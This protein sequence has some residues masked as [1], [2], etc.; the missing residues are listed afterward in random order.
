MP[1]PVTGTSDLERAV[2]AERVS[3]E[4]AVVDAVVAAA[5]GACTRACGAER[6]EPS[7]ENGGWRGGKLTRGAGGGSGAG[8]GRHEAPV[9]HITGVVRVYDTSSV[10]EAKIGPSH[11]AGVCTRTPGRDGHFVPIT[12]SAR[13]Q[14][15]GSRAEHLRH[16]PNCPSGQAAVDRDRTL[17]RGLVAPACR[18]GNRSFRMST[19]VRCAFQGHGRSRLGQRAF[20]RA[21]V[22]RG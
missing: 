20:D 17:A 9:A 7:E 10:L 4:V 8:R 21:M 2:A 18:R 19:V 5:G 11:T 1:G 3:R 13:G 15:M 6:R 22:P 14:P 12:H 16:R